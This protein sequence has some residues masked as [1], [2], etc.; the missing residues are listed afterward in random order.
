VDYLDSR[1]RLEQLDS[2][3]TLDNPVTMEIRVTLE[4]LAFQGLLARMDPLDSKALQE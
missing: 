3:E 4:E 2:R 1:D